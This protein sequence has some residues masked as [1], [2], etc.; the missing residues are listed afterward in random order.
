MSGSSLVGRARE[1][2]HPDSRRPRGSGQDSRLGSVRRDVGRRR[3]GVLAER[4]RDRH[5]R[6]LHRVQQLRRRPRARA[7]Q[8]TS[9]PVSNSIV[10]RALARS[11]SCTISA[12]C[13]HPPHHQLA[14]VVGD[15]QP[16]GVAEL[17]RLQLH[18]PVRWSA[19]RPARRSAAPGRGA[20]AP[21]SAAS[22]TAARSASPARWRC[23]GC[24]SRAR[25]RTRPRSARRS[26]RSKCPIPAG[27][28]L[29]LAFE[30]ILQPP[31]VAGAQQRRHQRCRQVAGRLPAAPRHPVRVRLL[32]LPAARSPATR[33]CRRAPAP[34]S[35]QAAATGRLC[36]TNPPASPPSTA[37]IATSG[38]TIMPGAP[39]GS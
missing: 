5:R 6:R 34:S 14:L 18:R 13:E 39:A 7:R 31:R 3:R 38:Q 21:A 15:E 28:P 2:P 23:A 17:R 33:G 27:A 29:D 26:P 25:F 9:A 16:V 30:A 4:V 32:L 1:A 11:T 8:Q 35:A 36:V 37:P 24:G 22:S 12:G 20:A 19:P 10:M